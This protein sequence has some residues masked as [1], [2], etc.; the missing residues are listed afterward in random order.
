MKMLKLVAASLGGA[1]FLYAAVMMTKGANT[2][3]PQSAASFTRVMAADTDPRQLALGVT[4]VTWPTSN[5]LAL[6]QG[7]FVWTDAAASTFGNDQIAVYTM[8]ASANCGTSSGG[9]PPGGTLLALV[10]PSSSLEVHG[11]HWPIASGQTLCASP[12]V[13]TQGV[14]MTWAGFTL[15]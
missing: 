8:A 7:P 6:A 13:P 2:A 10:P 9:V 14:T 1:L 4:P 12:T 5:T 15:Y 11:M 3:S